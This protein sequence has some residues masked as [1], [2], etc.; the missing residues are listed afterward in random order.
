MLVQ[1]V[2]RVVSMFLNLPGFVAG[3]GNKLPQGFSTAF[4]LLGR[5][6]LFVGKGFADIFANALFLVCFHGTSC[7]VAIAGMRR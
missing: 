7:L 2:D 1:K 6:L 3:V 4:A 5:N